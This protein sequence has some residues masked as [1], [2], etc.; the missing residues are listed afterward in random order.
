[1][2]AKKCFELCSVYMYILSVYSMCIKSVYPYTS[3]GYD[4]VFKNKKKLALLTFK[5][6]YAAS[7][8]INITLK[9]LVD[10][11]NVLIEK[12]ARSGYKTTKGMNLHYRNILNKYWI[13]NAF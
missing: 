10:K 12:A 11:I 5:K 7:W 9:L 13:L 6:Y 3:L 4:T 2:C 1:M 8:N